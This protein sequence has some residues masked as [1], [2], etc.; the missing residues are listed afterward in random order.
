[1]A[2]LPGNMS[3]RLG[4]GQPAALPTL[5]EPSRC[6]TEFHRYDLHLRNPDGLC[7]LLQTCLNLTFDSWVSAL[8]PS[9]CNRC[10]L[11][12]S[13]ILYLLLSSNK[14][15]AR[16]PYGGDDDDDD[17]DDAAWPYSFIRSCVVYPKD[18][19]FFHVLSV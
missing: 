16:T 10:L 13:H 1:L 18:A 2:R 19:D 8:T 6:L 11:S 5:T 17:D 9:A 12:F 14:Q 7:F 15:N 3:S 4:S